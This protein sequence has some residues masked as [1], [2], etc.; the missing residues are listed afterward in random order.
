MNRN[1][2]TENSCY[3]TNVEKICCCNNTY[4]FDKMLNT[5]LITA[6]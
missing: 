4:S 1:T 6:A 3:L 2:F 5:K